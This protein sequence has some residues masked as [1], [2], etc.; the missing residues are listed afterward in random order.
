MESCNV[1][2]LRSAT[3]PDGR[4]T[5]DEQ[6]LREELHGMYTQVGFYDPAAWKIA[7]AEMDEHTL[8]ILGHPVMEDWER[9]Y[10]EKLAEIATSR[11]GRILEIGFGMGIS[12]GS[13]SRRYG[14]GDRPVT[15]HIII[16]GNHDVANLARKFRD[17]H[18]AGVVRII[19]GL[20]YD[21]IGQIEDGSLDGI[22]HDAYPL[23]E[24]QVQNQAHFAD[25][26]YRLLKPG[27]IF[28]YFSDE[29][30]AYRPEHL[31]LLLEAGFERD[32][33][34]QEIVEVDVPADCAYWKSGTILA[35]ILHKR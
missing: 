16:E 18:P 3:G 33:I 13:I 4:S 20:S 14:K 31:K 34:G 5:V 28:T 30:T 7:S 19:E 1:D 25:T 21:V 11:G 15:E 8:K 35:P 23:E 26:A 6:R 24:S 22:L 10:M 2:T 17:E 27:G 29:P 12:A 32:D 9:P